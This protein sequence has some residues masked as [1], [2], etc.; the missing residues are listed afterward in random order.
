LRTRVLAF[1]FAVIAWAGP[2]LAHD[3]DAPVPRTMPAPEWPAGKQ[4]AH[5]ILV[6]IDFDVSE[7]GAVLQ[8]DIEHSSGDPAIDAA[9]LV[10][11]R[12]WV[13]EPAMR[14]DKPVLGHTHGFVRF[15]GT[16]STPQDAPSSVKVMGQKSTPPRSASEI[17]LERPVLG[18]APHRTASD[19]LQT[20]PGITMTSHGGEGAAQQIFF[21]GFDAVH[22][23]DIEIW[24]G[25][26]PVNDVSNIHGQ[27]YAD[28]NFL[29]PEIVKQIRSA[30]GT[31]DPRQGD[32]SVAGS[33]WLDLGY[34]EP[35]VTAKFTGGQFGTRRYFL[36]YHP[37]S[38]SSGT[39]AA[40]E[41]Y[42][43]DGFGP[44]RAAERTSVVGQAEFK[45]SDS[46]AARVMASTYAT[47]FDS[48]GVL[49]LSDV[50]SGKIDRFGTYDPHQGGDATRSQL[51]LEVARSDDESRLSVAPYVILRSMRLRE[52]FTGY[53]AIDNTPGAATG[54][55]EQQINDAT[56]FGLT[57]SYHRHF[58]VFAPND[59]FEAGVTGRTDIISQSQ[60]KL[61]I[62]SGEVTL[63][64][65]DSKVHATDIGGYADLA[66]HPI[67]R[68]TVR[69]GARIDGLA[70]SVED[71]G[72]RRSAQGAHIGKKGT[73]DFRIIGGLRAV[74]SYGDGFR[75]P[76]AR[77]LQQ[78]QTTPFTTVESYEAGLRYQDA[79]LRATTAV[80]RT[81]L[82]DDLA[83]NQLTAR[84]ERTPPTRRTGV[85][86]EMAAL[87]VPWLTASASLTYTHAVFTNTDGGYNSGDLLP[88]APQIVARTDLAWTPTF[89]TVLKRPLTGH[90]GLGGTYLGRRPL[91]YSEFGLDAYLVDVLASVRLKELEIGLTVYNLLD[92]A[93][94]DGEYVFA[95]Q[96]NRTGA[97]SLVP[98]R[99]ITEGA[100]RTVLGTVALYL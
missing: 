46:V 56:T 63:P 81:D 38:A 9:A 79:R 73:L 71:D 92:L 20:V 58:K 14:D 96:F 18:A 70:Y 87:P 1:G 83:F 48:A 11:A 57:S 15:V 2:A 6:E 65:V 51:V 25:G 35:G 80:F 100:P 43:T 5:D 93:W 44:A 64:E 21:R 95:S 42:S 3:A 66:V 84:N 97:P 98:Q 33:L 12:Q 31:Y 75:S 8:A 34:D 86:A 49:R 22:G 89:G 69:G 4:T 7:T 39:F 36:A 24:A 16:E 53:L 19:L 10:V 28:L 90:F 41:H 40:M 76:Q 61:S 32:F 74:A 68:L 23:Q 55:S 77:S 72:S 78:G 52:D 99:Q 13:F 27:G 91:P 37:E 85:T 17:T 29:M 47:S 54:N 59:T 45:L 82:S 30:P 67:S 26:A 60:K 50:D 62:E 88:Y 94:H